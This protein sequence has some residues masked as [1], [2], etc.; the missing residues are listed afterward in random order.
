MRDR[1]LLY[2]TV[3][4]GTAVGGVV[5]ALASH[6]AIA[7][8]G[9]GF[10]WGTLAVNVAGSILIGLYAGLTEPGGRVFAGAR[11]RHFVMTGICGGFTTFSVFSLETL[12]FAVEGLY[13]LAAGYVA[14]SL[15]TWLAAAWLG[16][17][18]ATRINKLGGA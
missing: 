13:W 1:L 12:R 7:H 4:L 18:W 3:A 16:H 14:F 5:R 11:Q 9:A 2:L 17:A 6:A 8:F 10:P 15:V